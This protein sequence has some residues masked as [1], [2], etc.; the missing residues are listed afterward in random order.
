MPYKY[1][2]VKVLVPGGILA[3]DELNTIIT[4][5]ELTQATDI[6][7]GDRQEVLFKVP[8]IPEQELRTYLKRINYHCEISTEGAK[9]LHKNIV[10][11]YL[12]NGIS[13]TTPW[14]KDEVYLEILDNFNTLPTVRVNI[15]DLRQDIVYSFTGD[16]NFIGSEQVNY[17]HVY[18]RYKESGEL[19]YFP[20]L[21]NTEDI[22]SFV[23]EYEQHFGHFN[24][25][26]HLKEQICMVFEDR[27]LE[28]PLPPRI[29]VP[30]FFNYEGLYNY[31]NDK[32]WLGIYERSGRFI[33]SELKAIAKLVTLHRLGKIHITPWK[34]LIIK[35]II[36]DLLMDWKVLMA[37]HN[38]A[39]GHSQA[40]LNW[41]L[42]DFDDHALRLKTF[43]RRK[44]AFHDVSCNGIIMGINNN[45]EYCFSHVFIEEKPLIKLGSLELFT[46]YSVYIRKG[47]F[48][49]NTNFR[50][51]SHRIWKWSLPKAISKAVKLY[52][53]IAYIDMANYVVP[54][55]NTKAK[56]PKK[57]KLALSYK[58]HQCSNCLTIYS[59]EHG[60]EF[61][62]IPA[63]TTFERLPKDFA[64]GVCQATKDNFIEL[65]DF[66]LEKMQ[67]V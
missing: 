20:Y 65:S 27:M 21:V 52:H 4:V 25:F 35:D 60:D 41:Q 40:E 57:K 51:I 37:M 59:E 56:K 1:K 58:F 46:L 34:T 53:K 61:L 7:F 48:P 28:S 63:K 67:L 6:R 66:D 38:I 54:V 14:M 3:P 26:E 47:F 49:I 16:L 12:A 39:N 55:D 23:L 50:R 8:P 18:F 13:P 24:N 2:T 30:E 62:A 44:L 9:T 45:P 19:F 36:E 10:T 33:N 22:A 17:W 11:S 15:T 31:Q 64:C 42:N 43:L 29:R 32:Y 5:C